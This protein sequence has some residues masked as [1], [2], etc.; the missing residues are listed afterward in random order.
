MGSNLVLGVKN[1]PNSILLLN[2]R[3]ISKAETL[4]KVIENSKVNTFKKVVEQSEY[5]FIGVKTI[6]LKDVLR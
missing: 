5:L 6:D 4:Q 1:Y 2:N 3:A